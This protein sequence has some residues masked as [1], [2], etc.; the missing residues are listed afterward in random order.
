MKQNEHQGEIGDLVGKLDVVEVPEI[1]DITAGDNPCAQGDQNDRHTPS[2]EP[3]RRQNDS[4]QNQRS[5]NIYDVHGLSLAPAIERIQIHQ[6]NSP[7]SRAS[8]A[9]IDE[10][11]RYACTRLHVVTSFAQ[12]GIYALLGLHNRHIAGPRR[13]RCTLA[14][15]GKIRLQ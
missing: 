15:T 14:A 4:D 3:Y 5:N 8:P 11:C 10:R 1:E 6:Q 2:I 9:D 12:E 7:S 13:V